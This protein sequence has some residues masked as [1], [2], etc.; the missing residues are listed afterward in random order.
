M[1]RIS[2]LILLFAFTGCSVT[3]QATAVLFPARYD[4]N[5][6]E[7]INWIRT[8]AE[9]SVDSCYSTEISRENF[10][11]LYKGSLEFKNFTQYL[12]RN[13]P[14]HDLA[15]NLHL[16]VDEGYTLYDNQEVSQFFCQTSLLQIADSATSIQQVIGRK[17]K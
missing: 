5:E 1:K 10:E 14:A 13:Q 7:L 4:T 2:L 3:N 12:R 8:T 6:Y 16:L 17:R 11:V 15:I 9:L